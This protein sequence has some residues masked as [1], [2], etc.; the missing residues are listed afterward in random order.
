ME[1]TKRC[2][3]C[4]QVPIP[5][6]DG[7]RVWLQCDKHGHCACGDNLEMAKN[8]WNKYITFIEICQK[9]NPAEELRLR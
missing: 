3:Q 7:D 8:H 2:P 1:D 5:I 6:F 4:Y 9:S